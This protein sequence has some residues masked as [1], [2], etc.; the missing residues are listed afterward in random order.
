MCPCAGRDRRGG[1]GVGS[2]P[3]VCAFPGKNAL[4]KVSTNAEKNENREPGGLSRVNVI[5]FELGEVH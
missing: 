4:T 2:C 3:C 1:G 5:S